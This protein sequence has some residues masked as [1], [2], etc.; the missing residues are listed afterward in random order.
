[1]L[2][3]LV[4]LGC[5]A[6]LLLLAFN[7][8]QLSTDALLDRIT[9]PSQQLPPYPILVGTNGE[10]LLLPD[11]RPLGVMTSVMT[12][13]GV[14][15]SGLVLVAGG[16]QLKGRDRLPLQLRLGGHSGRVLLGDE[17]VMTGPGGRPLEVSC[18][19]VSVYISTLYAGMLF[20]CDC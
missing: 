16:R 8:G 6:T 2:L 11:H 10:P 20:C 7:H 18:G 1:V 12:D 15:T 9:P 5:L 4:V 19:V 3:P 13:P 14:T 17:A